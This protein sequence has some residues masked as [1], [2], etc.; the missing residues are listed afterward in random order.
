[1]LLEHFKVFFISNA[2]YFKPNKHHIISQIKYVQVKKN[3]YLMAEV[4][5]DCIHCGISNVV[6]FRTISTVCRKSDIL[7]L[8]LASGLTESCGRPFCTIWTAWPAIAFPKW[9]HPCCLGSRKRLLKD[10][11]LQN[12]W[13]HLVLY[14]SPPPPPPS[15]L[16]C[17]SWVWMW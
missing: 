7:L 17:S 8:R 16:P 12:S 1:M 9:T 3:T 4:L 14:S 6:W 5:F 13:A 2:G 11:I 15:L 10:D